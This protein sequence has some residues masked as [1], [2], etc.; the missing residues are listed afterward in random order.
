M[1]L[2]ELACIHGNLS[3]VQRQKIKRPLLTEAYSTVEQKIAR[4]LVPC[5][6][7]RL[8]GTTPRYRTELVTVN[9]T[10]SREAII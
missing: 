6:S 9:R 7:A 2:P 3:T 10:L 8:S 4:V 5:V 1:S